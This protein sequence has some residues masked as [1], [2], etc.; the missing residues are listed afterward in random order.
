MSDYL[1]TESTRYLL[2]NAIMSLVVGE[3]YISGAGASSMKQEMSRNRLVPT[4]L[5]A[6]WS[7][8]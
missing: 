7:K 5:N 8:E 6:L 1:K 3:M 2:V 4:K